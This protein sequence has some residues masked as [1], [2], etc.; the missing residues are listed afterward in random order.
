VVLALSPRSA[1][2]PV[3]LIADQY[4]D[5]AVA[6]DPV[7]AA[8]QERLGLAVECYDAGDTTSELNV[9]ASWV[10]DV[11]HVFDLMPAD[12]EQAAVNVAR[13]MAAVPAADG[14]LSG[15]LLSAA[16]GGRPPARQALARL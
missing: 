4:V 2:A 7:R 13:R 11:R 9:I 8:M 12:G 10:H 14:Q 3:D 6:L 15:T 16:R 5:R 1:L